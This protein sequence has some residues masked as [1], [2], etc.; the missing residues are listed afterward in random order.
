MIK[1]V[2]FVAECNFDMNNIALSLM[3]LMGVMVNQ[4]LSEV[5]ISYCPKLIEPQPNLAVKRFIW[6][7]VPEKGKIINQFKQIPSLNY[8]HRLGLA[9]LEGPAPSLPPTPEFKKPNTLNILLMFPTPS[10]T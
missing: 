7:E 1:V 4:A 5:S 6:D 10:I 2:A 3:I 9:R 8:L